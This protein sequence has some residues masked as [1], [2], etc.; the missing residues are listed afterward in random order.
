MI[1][2]FLKYFVEDLPQ[3]I[4]KAYYLM[5]TDCGKKNANSIVY[6]GAFIAVMNTYFGFLYRL[7]TYFY[8]LKRL[9]R[10]THKLEVNVSNHSLA[11]YGFKNIRERI[12]HNRRAE[13]FIFSGE[14]Y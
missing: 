13:A 3:F 7:I 8:A 14:N 10:Y 11:S 6:L 4:V 1:Y 2:G 5:S 12:K 9:N